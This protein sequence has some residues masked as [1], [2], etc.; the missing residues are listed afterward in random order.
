KKNEKQSW[1]NATLNRAE[2]KPHA[3]FF[4]KLTNFPSPPLKIMPDPLSDESSNSSTM[5]DKVE[6]K[7]Q[8]LNGSSEPKTE[9]SPLPINSNGSGDDAAADAPPYNHHHR[10][11]VAGDNNCGTSDRLRP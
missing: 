3:L 5:L 4:L 6:A 9:S 2:G 11:H 8:E 7:S 1:L 10:T